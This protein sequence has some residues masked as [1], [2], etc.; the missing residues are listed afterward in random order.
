LP[1]KCSPGE[2]AELRKQIGETTTETF[3]W[4]RKIKGNLRENREVGR[5][6][7]VTRNII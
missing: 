2:E 5:R 4:A 7:R 6:V 1:W 3:S